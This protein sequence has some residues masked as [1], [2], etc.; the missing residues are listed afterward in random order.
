MPKATPAP[1]GKNS[2]EKN[3]ALYGTTEET[4][5]ETSKIVRFELN[6]EGTHILIETDSPDKVGQVLATIHK[7]SASGYTEGIVNKEI[8]AGEDRN[9]IE[10]K[11]ANL[12]SDEAGEDKPRERRLY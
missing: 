7:I 3:S 10:P 9:N 8:L 1:K 5:T 12:T 6:H 11:G 4:P 2:E